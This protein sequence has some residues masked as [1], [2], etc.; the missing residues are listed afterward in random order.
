MGLPPR[1]ADIVIFSL[2]LYLPVRWIAASPKGFRERSL[3]TNET[4]AKIDMSKDLSLADTSATIFH[5]DK[6]VRDSWG[7]EEGNP[8]S[9]ARMIKGVFEVAKQHHE[10]HQRG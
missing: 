7:R 2:K 6:H 8:R 1:D 9:P 4:L 5:A 10:K 3:P